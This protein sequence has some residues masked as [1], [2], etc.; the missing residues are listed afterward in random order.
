MAM[1]EPWQK[2]ETAGP[3]RAMVLTR[4]DVAATM[5][6]KAKRPLILAGHDAVDVVLASGRPI[7]YVVQISEAGKIPVVAAASV[8]KTLIGLGHQ[9]VALMGSVDIANRLTDKEWKGFDGEGSYDAL[10]VLGLPY[11]VGWLVLSGLKHFAP[12]LTTLN[13]DRYYQP[14]ATWSFP[15]TSDEGWEENLKVI[16]RSLGGKN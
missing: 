16:V 6:R 5:I 2:A 15:N 8:A 13:L 3:L 7:D 11:Y 1:A 4:A 12:D 14:H 10:L 9:P